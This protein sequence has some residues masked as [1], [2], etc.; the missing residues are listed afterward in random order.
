[1]F[2]EVNENLWAYKVNGHQ[3]VPEIEQAL[4]AL[5][6][7]QGLATT[8]VPH[9][10]PIDRG[11]LSTLYLR[12]TEALRWE[13]VDALY[14]ECYQEAPFVR[15]RPKDQWPRMRDVVGTNR[16]DLAFTVD[17]ATRRLIVVAAIDNLMKGAAGQAVQNLNLM[18]GFPETT[19]LQ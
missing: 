10:V 16:C 19:G 13:Q 11:I 4:A 2:A 3:H 15:I 8:F 5:A 18:C 12:T 9:V 1:M 17:E 14:R 6:N 7:I